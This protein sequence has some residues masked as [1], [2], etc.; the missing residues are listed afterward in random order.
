[1]VGELGYFG[2]R[3][4]LGALLADK[5]CFSFATVRFQWFRD[6]GRVHCSW[7]ISFGFAPGLGLYYLFAGY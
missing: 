4:G 7:R 5:K 6:M 2:D 3:S 1:V